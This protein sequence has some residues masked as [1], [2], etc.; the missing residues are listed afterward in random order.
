MHRAPGAPKKP[1]DLVPGPHDLARFRLVQPE[2]RRRVDLDQAVVVGQLQHVVEDSHGV[3][4]SPTAR[5]ALGKG[6]PPAFLGLRLYKR[7]IS[8]EILES[9]PYSKGACLKVDVPGGLALS[10][11][12]LQGCLPADAQGTAADV[13]CPGNADRR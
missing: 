12:V 8:L 13:F 7:E 1:L 9:E 5:N 10:S 11:V 2:L 3:L 4:A 6:D